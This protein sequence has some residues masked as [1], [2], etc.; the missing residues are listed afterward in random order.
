MSM[1]TEIISEDMLVG[2]VVSKVMG[3]AD[4]MTKYGL[5]CVGCGAS[6]FETLEQGSLGHGMPKKEF[7][8][9]MRELNELANKEDEK[10]NI[11]VSKLSIEIT[12]ATINKAKELA[13]KENLKNTALRIMVVGGGCSGYSYDLSFVENKPRKNDK[14][15]TKNNFNVLIDPESLEIMDG[16]I[17]DFVDNLKGSGF[18]I[19]NPSAHSTCG[20]GKSFS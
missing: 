18:K 7:E 5:H 10:T 20:C 17:I 3:S 12:D 19:T 1:A 2:E 6:V 11:D 15:I 8:K 14:I 4:V 16:S 9:M 13:K